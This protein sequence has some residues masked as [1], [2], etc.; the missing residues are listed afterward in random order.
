MA[1][2]FV[3]LLFLDPGGRAEAGTPCI[4]LAKT[5]P[6]TAVPGETITYQFIVTNCGPVNFASGIAWVVDPLFGYEPLWQGDLNAGNQVLFTKDYAVTESNCGELINI[7]EAYGSVGNKDLATYDV[8]DSDSWTVTVV[9]PFCGDGNLDPGE[10]CDD[11]NNDDG[12][13]CSASCGIEPYCGDG[14]L[15][16]GEEC[17]DGNN[18]DNDGCSALCT[19]ENGGEGCT[20]GYWK[21][22]QH[23]DSW[24]ASY[25]PNMMFSDVFENAFPDM[26][27]LDVLRQG[28]GCLNALGRHTVAALLNGESSEVDYDRSAMQIIN[29]FNAT[30]Q[31]TCDDY[32]AVKNI[33]AFFNEQG[34]PLN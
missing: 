15:D 33:F 30:Y 23:F 7:A 10:S 8:M 4:T 14:V 17:D 13:G 2:M 6:T 22:D 5:G 3:S 1:L 18:D 26:T 11:G 9:C 24:P 12:D 32:E 27:L 21:Q 20:P 19:I 31:G 34:C 28:G 29:M 25:S 16:P